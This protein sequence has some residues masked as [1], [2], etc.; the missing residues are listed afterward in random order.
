MSAVK[1][2]QVEGKMSV[3]NSILV[4]WG[5]LV[6]ESLSHYLGNGPES[7]RKRK[8]MW[9]NRM[10]TGAYKGCNAWRT[11]GTSEEPGDHR[12]WRKIRTVTQQNQ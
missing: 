2:R 11:S 6:G 4:V 5:L 9:L 12:G 10:E 1:Q 3:D 8:G 7:M